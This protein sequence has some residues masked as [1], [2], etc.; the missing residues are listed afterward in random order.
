M[1]FEDDGLRE[2]IRGRKLAPMSLVNP[3]GSPTQEYPFNP[4][5]SPHGWTSLCSP[6]GRHLAM[7]PH[8]ERCVLPWQLPWAP[9]ERRRQRFAP[10]MKLFQN[11][12]QW[13]IEH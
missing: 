11:A 13:C 7:M 10:W 9:A 5:G 1:H 4:N 2:E 12:Y 3:L 6:D 8:P